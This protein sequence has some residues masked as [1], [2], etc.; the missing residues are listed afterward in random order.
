MRSVTEAVFVHQ[1]HPLNP[2]STATV[3]CPSYCFLPTIPMSEGNRAAGTSTDNFSAIF[4]AALTEYQ[5]VTGKHLDT[6]PFAAKLDTC[7]S[8][9]AVSNVLRTQ[10]QA[11]SKSRRGD[12]KLMARL[13]PIVHILSAFSGTRRTNRSGTSPP[14]SGYD[15]SLMR[16]SQ[17]FSPAQTIFTGISILLEVRLVVRS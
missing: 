7:D 12:E 3:T 1:H 6:H 13:N 11:F 5:R 8:P 15:N 14:T 9:E 16:G 17:S 4:N 2:A 10:A